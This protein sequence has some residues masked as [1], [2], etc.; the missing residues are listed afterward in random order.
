MAELVNL[1]ACVESDL[2][3]RFVVH[4]RVKGAYQRDN[5][6]C[7]PS[8]LP[9]ASLPYRPSTL[10]YF[11]PRDSNYANDPAV[12][13]RQPRVYIR[14]ARRVYTAVSTLL[15]EALVLI[16]MFSLF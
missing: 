10:D 14:L 5:A 2:P 16:C 4:H 6:P 15:F 8:L 3:R 7:F 13:L 1:P 9:R 11:C 12:S